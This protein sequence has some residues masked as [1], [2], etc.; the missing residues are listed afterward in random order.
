MYVSHTHTGWSTEEFAIQYLNHLKGTY[1]KDDPGLLVWDLHASHRTN[2]V[3]AAAEQLSI[4]MKFIPAGQT[5]YW[6][7]LDN[8]VFGVLKAKARAMFDAQM[9][10]MNLKD[11]TIMNAIDILVECWQSLET[12]LIRGAWMHINDIC[13]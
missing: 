8:K 9:A 10:D 6:Q 12:E 3:K 13:D 7:P 11:V 2:N 1:L 4:G 5:D